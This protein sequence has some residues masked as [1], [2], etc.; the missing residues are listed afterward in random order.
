MYAGGSILQNSAYLSR[1]STCPVTIHVPTLELS[2][3]IPDFLAI[4]LQQSVFQTGDKRLI[5]F[6]R[7]NAERHL[8]FGHE[9]LEFV[10]TW[11]IVF[12]HMW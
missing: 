8:R 9:C 10:L 11:G 2:K 3:F 5:S 12:I 7:I 1:V 4:V 6:A